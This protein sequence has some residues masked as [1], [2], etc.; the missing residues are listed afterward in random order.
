[1]VI[2]TRGTTWLADLLKFIALASMNKI[3]KPLSL[4]S[5]SLLLLSWVFSTQTATAYPKPDSSPSFLISQSFKPPSRGTAP[6]SSGGATRGIS[7]L[8]PSE[9]P[10]TSLLPQSR[11]GLTYSSNP[12]FYWYVPQPS[13]KTAK[14]LLMG[15]NDTEVVYETTLN[16]PSQP[17]IVSFTLPTSTA[18]LAQNQQYHWYL[19]IGCSQFDQAANPSVEGWVERVSPEAKIASQLEKADLKTRAQI[20]AENGIWHEALAT[21]ATLR[22][23]TSAKPG[24]IAGWNELLKSVNLEA[25][26]AEPLLELSVSQN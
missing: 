6:P 5:L 22:K 19:I 25:I 15:N 7:C 23:A 8:K 10:L 11:V 26:A 2:D 20:Y 17:G 24:T 4:A 3:S 21:V 18:S 12:T 9:K 1:M 14:F 16:L 13:A